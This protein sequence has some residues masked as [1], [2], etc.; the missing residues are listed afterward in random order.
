MMERLVCL[1]RVQCHQQAVFISDMLDAS[2]KALDRRYL[3]RRQR[4]ESWS[5]LIFSQEKPPEKDFKL[6]ENA[7]LCIAPRGQLWDCI[8]KFVERGHMIWEWRYDEEEAKL[9]HLKGA[10]M[11]VYTPSLVPGHARHTN[12]WT[13]SCLDQPRINI[14]AIYTTGEVALGVMTIILFTKGPP[15]HE[16][17]TKFWEVLRRWQRTWL[18]ENLQWVGNDHWIA[19][20]I[21]YGTLIVVTD[22]SYMKDLYPNI[23]SAALVLECTKGRG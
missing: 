1:N 23:H 18:G 22:G 8:G 10:V 4:G 21:E 14:G 2:R 19:E 9:Y 17:L 5:T 6:W 11:D 13:R 7:L 15:T 16:K 20:V 12:R 3:K